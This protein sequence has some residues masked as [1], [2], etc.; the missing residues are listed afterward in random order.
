[1]D[2]FR[3]KGGKPLEGTI[4]LSGS[5]NSALPILAAS[6]LCKEP[7]D[8]KNIPRIKDI[9]VQINLL[10]D[11][12]SKVYNTNQNQIKIINSSLSKS[13]LNE[14]ARSIRGSILFLGPLLAREGKVKLPFPG[15]CDIGTRKIDILLAGLKKLGAKINI[16]DDYIYLESKNNLAGTDMRLR[17][18]SVAAT[19]NILMASTIAK[20]ETNLYNASIEPEVVDLERFLVKMGGSIDGIG[21]PNLKI[22][23]K[24]CLYG[25]D[26]SIKPDRIELGTYIIACAIT[27]GDITINDSGV[28]IG[29]FL[30]KAK[31]MGITIKR[32][33]N[34]MHVQAENRPIPTEV[35]TAPFPGFA[36]DLQPLIVAL[37]AIADGT[38][39]VTETIYN[40]RFSYIMELRKMGADIKIINNKLIIRGVKHL[41]GSCV[42]S[43][44]LR[45]GASLIIAGLNAESKTL[46]KNI[47]HIDRGYEN[48][49]L[50]LGGMGANINRLTN[51]NKLP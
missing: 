19:E 47:E 43:T 9:F 3:I 31:E 44:D 23:G 6:I 37:M 4:R 25:A 21:T 36:T 16:E 48:I 1:M 15:G 49:D 22:V 41:E 13:I 12:G 26:Y 11:L 27:G 34:T 39:S 45:G 51:Y 17:F 2:I 14:E 42:S 28:D 29:L 18:P 40:N 38:S 10:K 46:V 5:K 32:N 30:N 7:I 20:G 50:K 33:D 35:V 24:E 8:L